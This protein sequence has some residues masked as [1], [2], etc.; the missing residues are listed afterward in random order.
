MIQRLYNPW[1]IANEGER[2]ADRHFTLPQWE[3]G[4][5]KSMLEVAADALLD[6]IAT[7]LEKQALRNSALLN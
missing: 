7:F 2:A 1:N 6:Q 5:E 4:M 3:L